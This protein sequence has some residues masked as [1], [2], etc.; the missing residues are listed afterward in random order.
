MTDKQQKRFDRMLEKSKEFEPHRYL[1]KYVAPA[2]QKM[3]RAEAGAFEGEVTAIHQGV[4]TKIH[5]SLGDCVCVTCGK[6][7]P[8]STDNKAG[9]QG[10]DAGHFLASRRASIVLEESNCHPQCQFCNNFQHG[11]PEAY[12]RW[13]EAVYGSTEID[14]LKYLLNQVSK[15][16]TREELVELRIAYM[17]RTK[18]AIEKMKG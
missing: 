5:S 2:F 9:R 17:D 13:M 1:S 16:W 12:T 6:V 15:Q 8:W 10:V 7:G 4:I 11:M 14:R 3:V 18:A